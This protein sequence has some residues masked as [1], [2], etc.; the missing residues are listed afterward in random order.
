MATRSRHSRLWVVMVAVAAVVAALA[1][2]LLFAGRAETPT[3]GP[4]LDVE[5]PRPSLPDAPRL[6]P[7][8]PPT[9]PS[10][11]P[12]PAPVR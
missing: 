2:W 1:L 12:A 10:P 5:P 6:P 9:V 4:R 11:G 8:E 3:A 7:V